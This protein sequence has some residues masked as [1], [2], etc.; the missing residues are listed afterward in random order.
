MSPQEDQSQGHPAD[1]GGCEEGYHIPTYSRIAVYS[2]SSGGGRY[3][4]YRIDPRFLSPSMERTP[5]PWLHLIEAVD[6]L[7]FFASAEARPLVM[8]LGA[9]VVHHL[10]L[11]GVCQDVQAIEHYCQL[12]AHLCNCSCVWW[13]IEYEP[14]IQ[15]CPSQ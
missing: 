8:T 5:S 14:I 13:T 10:L 1:P 4:D 7:S 6:L 11:E 9:P 12:H 15:P 2:E 3:T